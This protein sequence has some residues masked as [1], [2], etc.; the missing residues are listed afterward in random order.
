MVRIVCLGDEMMEIYIVFTDTK[1]SFAKMIKSYT[2][3]PFSH[4]SLSFSKDLSQMYSFGLKQVGNAF[5]G[6][7][8]KEDV[9]DTLFQRADCAVCKLELSEESYYKILEYVQQMEQQQEFFKYN[10]TGLFAVALNYNFI[11]KDAYFCSE[12]VAEALAAGNIRVADKPPALVTP[13][14]LFTSGSMATIH[15]GDVQNYPF[16]SPVIDYVQAEA[17]LGAMR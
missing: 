9:R 15:R 16:L 12:F 4:V 8:V 11:R 14:D 2:R 5:I 7:F 10:L 6:G 1:T 13:R 3:Y 17:V